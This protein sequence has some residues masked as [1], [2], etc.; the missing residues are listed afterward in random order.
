MFLTLIN[1]SN[2]KLVQDLTK[3]SRIKSNDFD[4]DKFAHIRKYVASRFPTSIKKF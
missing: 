4:Y 3:F 2:N 1:I